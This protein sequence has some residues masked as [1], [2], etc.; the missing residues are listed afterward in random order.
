MSDRSI[1]LFDIEAV[2]PNGTHIHAYLR[3][4]GGWYV[5]HTC[6]YTKETGSLEGIRRYPL[7]AGKAIRVEP[8]SRFSAKRLAALAADP[9]TLS[10]A[11]LL[12]GIEDEDEDEQDEDED[13]DGNTDSEA[14]TL[15]GM[16]GGY[17]ALAEF[18]GLELD[19]DTG[20]HIDEE[21]FAEYR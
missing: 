16:E 20:V 15:A 5:I 12:A 21:G 11:Y 13:E 6:P 1:D 8:C 14:R 4:E 18:D 10:E 9:E 7:M 2:T 17:R 3:A 19:D